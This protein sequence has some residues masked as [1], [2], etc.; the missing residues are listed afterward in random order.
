MLQKNKLKSLLN[1]ITISNNN[2]AFY[3]KQRNN[4]E[5]YIFD[6][7]QLR[8][9]DVLKKNYDNNVNIVFAQCW[10]LNL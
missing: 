8:G 4:N 1:L 10:P 7:F 9:P 2:L 6:E 3:H 5:T